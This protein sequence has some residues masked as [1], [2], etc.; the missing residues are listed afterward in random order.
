MRFP[1]LGCGEVGGRELDESIAINHDGPG[2]G[3]A[4]LCSSVGVRGER[5]LRSIGPWY[6]RAGGREVARGGRARRALTEPARAGHA[7]VVIA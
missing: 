2:M 1:R 4:H 5:V 6:G 3:G 7:A